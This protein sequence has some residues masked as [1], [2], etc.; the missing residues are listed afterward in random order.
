MDIDCGATYCRRDSGLILIAT[1]SLCPEKCLQMLVHIYLVSYIYLQ[2]FWKL[3]SAAYRSHCHGNGYLND[4]KS[5]KSIPIASHMIL[6]PIVICCG[7]SAGGYNSHKVHCGQSAG[8]INPIRTSAR[9]L[10]GHLI[11][12]DHNMMSFTHTSSRCERNAK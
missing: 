3:S 10:R 7:Q 5:L 12:I 2:V 11:I 6:N 9:N 1:S 4:S 8:L